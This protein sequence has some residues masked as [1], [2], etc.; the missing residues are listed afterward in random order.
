MALAQK[1]FEIPNGVRKFRVLCGCH[2]EGVPVGPNPWDIAHVIY[3]AGEIIETNHDLVKMYDKNSG[4]SRK[5][6]DVTG[7]SHQDR[8]RK[9]DPNSYSND[10]SNPGQVD[11]TSQH[12][13][14]IKQLQSQLAVLVAQHNQQ[15]AEK[16]AMAKQM[17]AQ[18]QLLAQYAE[19][20]EEKEEAPPKPPVKKS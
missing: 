13:D 14:S 3:T 5:F 16:A 7:T 10:P 4:V 17:E 19:K 1:G 2:C 8:K 6:E 12:G 18:A 11:V 15:N 20:L 9:A